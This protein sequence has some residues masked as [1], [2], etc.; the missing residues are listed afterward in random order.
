MRIECR[1]GEKQQAG[2]ASERDAHCVENVFIESRT[3]PCSCYLSR[4]AS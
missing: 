4:V 2:S 1:H 3:I